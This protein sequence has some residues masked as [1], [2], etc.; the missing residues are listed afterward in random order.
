VR[1]FFKGVSSSE[2]EGNKLSGIGVVMERSPGVPVLKVQK[3]LD[4]CGGAGGRALGADGW[5]AGGA[6]E[7]DT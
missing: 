5:A 7:W 1:L 2:A 3:K 6:T 4:F